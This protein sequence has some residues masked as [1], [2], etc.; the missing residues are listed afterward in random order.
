MASVALGGRPRPRAPVGEVEGEHVAG[1]VDSVEVA[2]PPR[3]LG[4]VDGGEEERRAT[5][6]AGVEDDGEGD[7]KGEQDTSNGV[8]AARDVGVRAATS[9]PAH[10]EEEG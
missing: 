3:G 5:A 10:G 9:N 4:D 8:A 1:R 6:S 7:A 2:A